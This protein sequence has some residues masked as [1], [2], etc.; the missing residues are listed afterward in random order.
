MYYDKLPPFI[1]IATRNAGKLR[2][3]QLLFHS[4]PT[5]LIG[6]DQFPH[7]SVS[8][9]PYTTYQENAVHKA[10]HIMT[11]VHLPVLA[12]DSGLEIEA[13]PHLL[14]VY[15]ARY[16][17]ESSYQEKCQSILALLEGKPRGAR[18]VAALALV[19]PNGHTYSVEGEC[20]GVIASQMQGQRG[21]G[22]DPIFIP[23]GYSITYAEM[24][25]TIKNT[26]SHRANAVKSLLTYLGEHNQ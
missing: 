7:V 6:L 16:L 23:N 4:L 15:S 11:Q 24:T 26:I 17:P 20:R 10:H 1:V 9:E 25:D 21:F 12:D 19:T 2:E 18:F 5:T 13:L 14:G 3:F 8:D 22:Y